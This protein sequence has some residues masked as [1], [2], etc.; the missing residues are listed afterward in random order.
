MKQLTSIIIISVL[1]IG[2]NKKNTAPSPVSSGTT[3]SGSEIKY[4]PCGKTSRWKCIGGDSIF[5]D[6]L[7]LT[8][9][10]TEKA[11]PCDIY[12]YQQNYSLFNDF[13]YTFSVSDCVVVNDTIIIK[14]TDTGKKSIFKRQN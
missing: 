5:T 3:N 4:G 12:Y 6:I 11:Q 1:A 8:H 13:S 2:C 14:D 7:S 10:Y 9:F